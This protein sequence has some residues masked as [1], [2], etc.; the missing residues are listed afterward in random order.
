MDA[1]WPT[2]QGEAIHTSTFLGN[3]VGCA[4]A[5]A[6]IHEISRQKLPMRARTVGTGIIK[7]L[8]SELSASNLQINIRG[9]G[10]L[11][12]IE[13][14][15]PKGKPATSIALATI[16]QMLHEGYILL[17]EGEH[18]NVISLTPPLT[19]SEAQLRTTVRALARV[20]RNVAR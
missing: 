15:L 13:L 14:L 18:A 7:F 5:L 20:L 4:M 2:S 3:P 1:A 11:I 12:G 16:K 8:R 17:P 6:Q 9:A 10:L 19:T